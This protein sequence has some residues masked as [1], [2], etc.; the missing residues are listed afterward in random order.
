MD[1]LSDDALS[2]R[3]FVL[4]IL[5]T[6]VLLLQGV[7]NIYS[8]NGVNDSIAKVYDSVNEV[9]DTASDISLPITELRQLSMSL[10]MAPSGALREKIMME[11]EKQQTETNSSLN[12]RKNDRY[13]D[14]VSVHLFSEI[15]SAWEDYSRSVD[16]TK[17]YVRE[18]V[19]IAEFISVTVHEKESYLRVTKAISAYNS[20]LLK[21]SAETF[22]SAQKNAG[23]AFWAVV[24]TTL[25]EILILKIILSYVLN[26]VKTYITTKKSHEEEIRNI[27]RSEEN[28]KRIKERLKERILSEEKVKHL[29]NYLSNIINSMPSVLIAVDIENRVVQWN[30]KAEYETGVT[31]KEAIGQDLGISF[32]RLADELNHVSDA[33][34]R[35]EKKFFTRKTSSPNGETKHEDVT[36]YPLM[37]AEVTGAVIRVDDITEK[38]VNE[39]ALRRA[40]KMESIGQLT[41]GIAHDFNNILAIV[42]GNLELM[43][44]EI[45]DHIKTTENAKVPFLEKLL[46]RAKNAGKAASRATD[47]TRELLRL[48][49]FKNAE[50]KVE[51]ANEV[52]SGM[53]ELLIKS[54]TVSIEFDTNLASNL[55]GVD[56]VTGDLEDAILNLSL[57][58]KDAMS[59]DGMLLIETSNKVL[60]EEYV[61]GNP[62]SRVGDFVLIAISDTG[63]GMSEEVADRIFD[64]F[65]TTKE[66]GEGT[67]LGLSMVYSFVERSGGHIT[68]YSEEGVGTTFNLFL[69][70]IVGETANKSHT[71][72]IAAQLPRGHEV[73]LVVDDEEELVRTTSEHLENL[74]YQV[75]VALNAEQAL[76]VMAANK[77]DLVFSDIVMPGSMNGYQLAEKILGEY[78]DT[79]IQ[80]A[81]GFIKEQAKAYGKNNTQLDDL[82]KGRLHKPY[83]YSDLAYSI[84]NK[85]DTN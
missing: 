67:G 42:I 58:A 39:L 19:R 45:N 24:I 9:S 76:T 34:A 69:P 20:Y 79:K 57:N 68:V 7:Y 52:V 28:S 70:R 18:G 31:A 30:Y 56:V 3:F 47:L 53:R 2:R 82:A 12:D 80:L 37:T 10:V 72:H 33:I 16:V 44:M 11:I 35:N 32:P 61:K 49:G 21:T 22:T 36:I 29:R 13:V 62:G 50:S 63:I 64:P 43:E 66:Y 5:A 8:L 71:D 6:S 26:L 75:V 40:Q 74:G 27:I 55:W 73:I 23:I 77:V 84:R 38:S 46:L 48:S 83:T 17:A 85:L 1:S 81:S 54:L 51:N 4:I 15:R 41:G 59:D 65:Y 14:S 25:V 60:D 78:P